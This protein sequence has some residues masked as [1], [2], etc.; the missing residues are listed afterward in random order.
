MGAAR[1]G[2]QVLVDEDG[3]DPGRPEFD[4]EG[5]PGAEVPD[6]WYGGQQGFDEVLAMVER[7]VDVIVGLVAER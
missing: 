3:L 1:D 7:T 5:G 2:A 6:P 4:P